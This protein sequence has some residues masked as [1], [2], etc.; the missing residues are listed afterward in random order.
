MTALDNIATRLFQLGFLAL[1]LFIPFS[2]AGENI[3]IG[4][5]VLAWLVWL[6]ARPRAAAL[7]RSALHRVAGAHRVSAAV[8]L[9][10]RGP[11]PRLCRLGV[12]LAASHLLHGG[13][14]HGA[15]W[16]CVT[17]RVACSSPR[18][19]RRAA[20]R[21]SSAQAGLHL[22]P[23]HI[24]AEHR[25]S[26]TLFTMTLA[27]ILCQ[28]VVF[29]AV[30]ALAPRAARWRVWIV[31]AA[32]LMFAALLLTMTRGAWIAVFAGLAAA[33]V[34]LRSRAL[35]VA[36]VLAI[37]VMLVYT[38]AYRNDQG[39]TLAVDTFATEQADRNVATRLVLWD[40][41]WHMFLDHPLFGVGMGD[42]SIE[43][44]KAPGG[45]HVRTTVDSHNIY[46]Q[47]L[48]TR[49]LLGFVPFVAVFR[50]TGRVAV[51]ALARGGARIDGALL[52]CRRAGGDGRA[53]GGRA[54]REQY[55]R[56]RSLHGVY[57]PGGN[58]AGTAWPASAAVQAEPCHS[59]AGRPG[60]RS[61]MMAAAANT[62][63]IGSTGIAR[64]QRAEEHHR[65]GRVHQNGSIAERGARASAA[66]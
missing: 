5:T 11:A 45:R 55:R 35:I 33:C 10:V 53:A 59:G 30:V 24:G 9:H 14:A 26:S 44:G 34:L 60:P 22:G 61:E 28:L 63:I 20:W 57:V 3:A 4:F 1:A 25:V 51:E 2:I 13:R 49:G 56:C 41:S 58:G 52:R 29:G 38:H 62:Q 48:A 42:Y 32:G 7:V 64:S 37:A 46:L 18:R 19:P 50:D 21:S 54:D 47:L 17:A 8:G 36:T 27:G 31:V 16:G 39:R 15:R 43:A 65:D 23:I 12:V 6:V 40:M 66:A